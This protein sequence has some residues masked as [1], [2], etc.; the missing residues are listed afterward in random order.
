MYINDVSS[1]VCETF[2]L[3]V[4]A[5]RLVRC[6]HG[7]EDLESTLAAK[8]QWQHEVTGQQ[9]HAYTVHDCG[10]LK[11]FTKCVTSNF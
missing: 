8:W 5:V 11:Y 9:P 10:F 1:T 3:L 6:M 2:L 4:L 7:D